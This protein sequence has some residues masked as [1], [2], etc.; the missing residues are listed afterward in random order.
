MKRILAA[1]G[2]LLCVSTARA[3]DT[4]FYDFVN[5]SGAAGA[6]TGTWLIPITKG[7]SATFSTTP[8]S[9]LSFLQGQSWTFA[10]GTVNFTSTTQLNGTAFGTAATKNTGTS[11]GT[12]CLL[13]AS[14]TFSGAETFSSTLLFSGLSA[15]TQVSCLG[16]DSGNNVV[17]NAAACGSGGGG[18]SLT[19]ADTLGHSVSSTTTLTAEAGFVVG[20]SAGSATLTPYVVNSTH[21]TSVSVANIGGQDN[22]NGSSLTATVPGTGTIGNGQSIMVI[23]QAASALTLSESQT[24][25]GCPVSSLA[26][27]GFLFGTGNG[28]SFDGG[29][30]PGFGALSSDITATGAGVVTIASSAVTTA[31]I[32]NAAVT[33]AKVQNGASNGLLGVNS[34]AAPTE[35]AVGS[36]LSLSGGT[37]TASASAGGG[38]FNYSDNG[39][40]VTAGTYFTP[41]GGGGIPQA[42]EANVQVKAPSALTVNNLQVG[43]S[44]D[45]GSG[46]TLAVTMRKAGS[47][48]TLTCTVTGTGG[49]TAISCQDLTHSISVAQNDLIDWKVVTTGTYVATPTITITANSGTTNNGVTG[50]AVNGNVVKGTGSAS[51]GDSGVVAANLVVAS[52]P[53]AGIAHFAG[54]TQT[55]TSS[56]IVAAD[57]TSATITGTQI[58]SSLA[59]AGSPTTTTQ[60]AKDNST[61]IATTAYVDAPTGLTAGTSVSLAAP[62]QYF[63]CTSTC[64]V[65]PPTPAAGYEFCVMNDDNVS[66]VIT[67]AAIASVSYE[68]TAR[69]SYGTANH[70]FTSGGAAADKV[71]ILGRDSTH[72]LTVS[73][74]GT[75]TLN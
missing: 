28:S 20:G 19:V 33:Y 74:N 70:T 3:A 51:V 57:I 7:G 47:D 40:T 32:N 2:L 37:L 44:A 39:V 8:N 72:Y 43:I 6:L 12:L 27:G 26:Q 10:T 21:T 56:A 73:F 9:L 53:G 35:V 71:C 42:T 59:L 58:A 15:G 68:S 17:L 52:S 64:T 34:G 31:K 55:V 75:W 62:R 48:Q 65:T 69:T 4:H 18:G 5:G 61:K 67:M 23:N 66:T 41:I 24:V 46:Q 14:C 63:V 45:P 38:T 60:S 25:N 49:G 36:G 16:L 50:S 11:G 22:Y 1:L 54:S 30:F 13:N 29:C